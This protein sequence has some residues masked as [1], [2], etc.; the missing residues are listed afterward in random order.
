[1][2]A[3]GEVLDLDAS[4]PGSTAPEASAKLVA[5]ALPSWLERAGWSGWRR[6]LGWLLIGLGVLIALVGS[7][8]LTGAALPFQDPT[9]QMLARQA[10][11]IH[12]AQVW[13]AVGVLVGLVAICAGEWLIVQARRLE[14]SRR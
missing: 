6:E 4:V 2:T 7:V 10:N 13:S 8:P 12:Q 9:P 5:M 1:V 14:Q 3:A 11:D